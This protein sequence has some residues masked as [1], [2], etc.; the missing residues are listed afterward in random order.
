[1]DLTP[2]SRLIGATVREVTGATRE[3]EEVR[4]VTDRGTLR[5]WHQGQC[6]ESVSVEDVTGDPADLVGGVVSLA[7]ERDSGPMPEGHE[8]GESETWTFYEIRTTRGDL[9]LRWLGTSN[10]YYSESVD[11]EWIAA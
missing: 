2:L 7:E 3:S 9:T 4:I 11:S 6:C 10:G 8:P 5:L 1:M